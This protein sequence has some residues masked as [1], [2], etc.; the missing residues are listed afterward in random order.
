MR[1]KTEWFDRNRLG[2]EPYARWCGRTAGATPPPTRSA[3]NSYSSPLY[4]AKMQS[5]Q[6]NR[7]RVVSINLFF[8][9]DDGRKQE[10]Y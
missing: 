7:G 1:Q 6:E 5:D 8:K 9:N 4:Y 10:A 2:T 3:K